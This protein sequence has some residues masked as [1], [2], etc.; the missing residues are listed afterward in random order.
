MILFANLILSFYSSVKIDV[1]GGGGG[2]ENEFAWLHLVES[3]EWDYGSGREIEIE[4][5][6]EGVKV[7]LSS[8][9]FCF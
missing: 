7:I 2:G 6:M 8:F 9:F 3:M 5:T 1:G 4:E